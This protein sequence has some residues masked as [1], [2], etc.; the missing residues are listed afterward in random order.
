MVFKKENWQ[1][2][3][4]VFERPDREAKK[5]AK[6][7]LF[8][9]RDRLGEAKAE[10]KRQEA[11]A[12][13]WGPSEK[14]IAEYRGIVAALETEIHEKTGQAVDKL[15]ATEGEH[16]SRARFE[17]SKKDAELLRE[18]AAHVK[19]EERMKAIQKTVDQAYFDTPMRVTKDEIARL[20]ERYEMDPDGAIKDREED[21]EPTTEQ[22]EAED[23]KRAA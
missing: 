10:L 19:R 21:L 22:L 4:P 5:A 11:M 17:R 16:A 14:L 3:A 7:E 9:L 2:Q 15:V 8:E 1:Q 6:A 20:H 12:N 13:G 18:R 23:R